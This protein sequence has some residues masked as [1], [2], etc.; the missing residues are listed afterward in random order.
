[1]AHGFK[2]DGSAKTILIS[3][4]NPDHNQIHFLTAFILRYMRKSMFL[5]RGLIVFEGVEF[6]HRETGSVTHHPYTE[7]GATKC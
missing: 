6:R 5:Y 1:M 4:C 7:Y 2:S 3:V